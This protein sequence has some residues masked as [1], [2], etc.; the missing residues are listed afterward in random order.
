MNIFLEIF[1]IIANK[2]SKNKIF[3]ADG[4]YKVLI[5]LLVSDSA[6]GTKKPSWDEIGFVIFLT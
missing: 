6:A 4:G 3:D 5:T 2:D 1:P